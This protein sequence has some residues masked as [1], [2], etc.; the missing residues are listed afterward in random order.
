MAAIV[1]GEQFFVGDM[2]AQGYASELRRE[3]LD[4]CIEFRATVT[5]TLQVTSAA[6]AA[7]S[8]SRSEAPSAQREIWRSAG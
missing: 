4:L 1:Q 5:A 3:P 6:S 7:K 8:V 2:I